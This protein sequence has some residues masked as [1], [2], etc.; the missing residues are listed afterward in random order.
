V[1]SPSS[2]L[3]RCPTNLSRLPPL[4]NFVTSG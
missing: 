1:G 2:V 4:N 3:S